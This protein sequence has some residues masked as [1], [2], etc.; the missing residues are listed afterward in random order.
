ME[1]VSVENVETF[2]SLVSMISY[3]A[4]EKFLSDNALSSMTAPA[5]P[6]VHKYDCK[7]ILKI[8]KHVQNQIPDV[9]G[10]VAIVQCEH[11][12]V[13][14][15]GDAAKSALVKEVFGRSTP[16]TQIQQGQTPLAAAFAEAAFAEMFASPSAKKQKKDREKDCEKKLLEMPSTLVA[17]LFSHAMHKP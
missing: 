3:D 4:D 14:W 16:Q 6:L 15:L 13:N 8:L 9:A 11:G 7:G 2:L 10:I 12:D 1:D 5:M 17:A